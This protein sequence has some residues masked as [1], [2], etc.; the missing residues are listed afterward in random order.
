MLAHTWT[1]EPRARKGLKGRNEQGLWL[2]R[3]KIRGQGA[4][5]SLGDGGLGQPFAQNSLVTEVV[6]NHNRQAS[7]A[8]VPISDVALSKARPLSTGEHGGGVVE[9]LEGDGSRRCLTF[10][11]TTALPNVPTA[12]PTPALGHVAFCRA[13]VCAIRPRHRGWTRR[14]VHL[15][16]LARVIGGLRQTLQLRGQ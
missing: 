9:A 13:A 7:K 8:R 12:L 16:C 3:E 10:C 1:R 5:F 4:G 15:C 6:M 11:D 2:R 14:R